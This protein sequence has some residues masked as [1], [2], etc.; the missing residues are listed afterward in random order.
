MVQSP[1]EMHKHYVEKLSEPTK[2][3]LGF[4]EYGGQ[5]MTLKLQEYYGKN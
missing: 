1:S 5:Q 4:N 2:V 3:F